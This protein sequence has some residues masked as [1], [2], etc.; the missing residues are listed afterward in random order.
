MLDPAS[1]ADPRRVR[2]VC[3][4]QLGHR[5]AALCGGTAQR[6]G[7]AGERVREVAQ[8]EPQRRDLPARDRVVDGRDVQ[9][10]DRRIAC[11]RKAGA[12]RAGREHLAQG[13]EVAE[14][15][16]GED[17]I[18]G[19]C[20][21]EQRLDR[22]TPL[23]PGRAQ[24]RHEYHPLERHP[25]DAHWK[26]EGMACPDA[27]VQQHP[28][29]PG[30]AC[31]GGRLH[32][33]GGVR[34]AQQVRCLRQYRAERCG[35]TAASQVPRLRHAAGTD[36]A[37]GHLPRAVPWLARGRLLPGRPSRGHLLGD[38]R[39]GQG[40]DLREDRRA[41]AL[42]DHCGLQRPA[43]VPQPPVG[44][45]RRDGKTV[46]AV[47]QAFMG[48][49]AVATRTA[50]PFTEEELLH[51]PAAGQVARKQGTQL[52]VVFDPRVQ[53]VNQ[54]VDR[55]LTADSL[56]HAGATEGPESRRVVQQ[57]AVRKGRR[58]CCGGLLLRHGCI[59]F[60][61]DPAH[62]ADEGH[63]CQA[64]GNHGP[65]ETLTGDAIA[66]RRRGRRRRTAYG[67]CRGHRITVTV[68]RGP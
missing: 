5:Q 53:E 24:R 13:G 18:F 12:L 1:D 38:E 34:R 8:E 26:P 41:V 68:S 33:R 17:V 16:R 30:A 37:P 46:M 62:P 25:G 40:A 29:D 52:L 51:R 67:S 15:C 9:D 6:P 31:Q 44:E 49:L 55:R 23:H 22:G 65:R 19:A 48:P 4:Q 28:D 39:Q 57:A 2:P 56:K 32:D 61:R 54:R 64:E 10:V 7:T 50:Q 27:T 3:E 35:I 14:E 43:E 47:P 36:P 58:M 45:R 60:G 42:R 20:R 59:Q 21:H 11:L 66:R 63:A